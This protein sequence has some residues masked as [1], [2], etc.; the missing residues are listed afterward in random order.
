MDDPDCELGIEVR[1]E[2]AYLFT[3]VFE[4]VG[5][6][7][8]G[9]QGKVVSLFSGGLRS[10]MSFFLMLK[11]GN[12]VFPLVLDSGLNEGCSRRAIRDGLEKLGNF[13][14]EIEFITISYQEVIDEISEKVPEG[15]RETVCNRFSF[16]LAESLA[17]DIDAKALVSD[18]SLNLLSERGLREVQ[19]IEGKVD[20][21]VLY[22]LSG[23]NDDEIMEMGEG[24][25]GEDISEGWG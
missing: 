9:T 16:S 18:L 5:G 7:P 12:K 3:E 14:R 10:L 2:D 4:G 23:F 22:P 25:F 8:V 17:R 20:M 11:R 19:I 15:L 6:L 1:D 24:L 13:H 21:P